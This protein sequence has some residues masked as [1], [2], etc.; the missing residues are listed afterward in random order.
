MKVSY[1][2]IVGR[3]RRWALYKYWHLLR[4]LFPQKVLRFRLSD[5]S[6]LDY[7]VQGIIAGA[8]LAD[9]FEH[10]EVQFLQSVLRP[11]NVV[12]DIG[13]NG[14]VFTV[15]SARKVGAAGAVYAFEPGT[16]ELA[17]LRH[18]IGLNQLTNVV[19]VEQAVSNQTGTARFLVSED[20][21]MNSL[22]QNDH[23]AQH[24]IGSEEVLTTTLDTFLEQQHIQCVDLVKVDVEGAEHHVFEGMSALLA[25][26]HQLILLFEAADSN[27][28]G[29]GYRIWDFLSD[30]MAKG[31][32]LFYLTKARK[33]I[34]VT[35]FDPRYGQDIYNFIAF[36]FD[37]H[38]TS[39]IDASWFK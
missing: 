12:I 27:A 22:A 37:P 21:A 38:R 5:G 36:N 31:L 11:G 28:S 39:R 9:D 23:P 29:F 3:G 13:A 20:G 24:V 25:S 7:P 1:R 30:L 15:L 2:S 6:R 33:L 14:G 10:A 19:V 32:H 16:R 4:N 8:L 35:T 18:N 26:E 17:L 34:A